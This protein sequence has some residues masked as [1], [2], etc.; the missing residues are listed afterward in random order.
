MSLRREQNL[1]VIP[2]EKLIA[3]IDQ[4]GCD[5]NPHEG[6]VPLQGA[7]QPSADG[8]RLR[9]VQQIFLRNLGAKARKRAEN[10]QPA[11]YQNEQRNRVHPV[12][13][14]H[15]QRMF[16]HSASHCFSLFAF[17]ANDFDYRTAHAS[18]SRLPD[19]PAAVGSRGKAPS[20]QPASC[21]RYKTSQ[22][23]RTTNIPGLPS[24]QLCREHW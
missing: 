20:R 24:S 14:P 21:R 13:Q 17:C 5:V 11:A 19:F 16:I 23:R 12:A 10:L 18:A 4:S 15:R 2:A 3:E 9:P 6:Q 22:H 1:P 8:Q 7:A